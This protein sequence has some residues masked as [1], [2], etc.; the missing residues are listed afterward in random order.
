MTTRKAFNKYK[1]EGTIIG[2]LLAG[3]ADIELGL[4]HCVNA[5]RD[6]FDTV[7]KAMFKTRG[8][9]RR[10]DMANIFGK[11]KYHDLGLGKQFEMAISSTR[12]CLKIRNQYAH[13]L[14]YDDFSGDL[15]FTNLEEI[16]Q[17]NSEIKDLKC[18]TIRHIDVPTL[19]QQES[20]FECTDSF[21]TWLNFEGRR[22]AGKPSTPQQEAPKQL[23]RPPLYKD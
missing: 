4:F 22:L 5:A 9:T 21:L 20:Y 18:L 2:R 6:D 11:Q 19:A 10:I 8:E 12:Y 16:A 3:Y 13:C 14:W 17:N 15:A 23:K 1:D 7:Y